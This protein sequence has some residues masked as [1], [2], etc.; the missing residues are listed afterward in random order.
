VSHRC[1]DAWSNLRCQ[2][3]AGHTSAHAARDADA[4]ISWRSDQHGDRLILDWAD[5]TEQGNSD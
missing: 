4:L 2:L 3:R 5:A 1:D